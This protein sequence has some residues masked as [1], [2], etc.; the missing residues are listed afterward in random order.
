MAFRV[1]RFP[2]QRCIIK[3]GLRP[4]CVFLVFASLC[5]TL[6]PPAA[7]L[8]TTNI[9]SG[10]SHLA[11]E[12]HCF[13]RYV[14]ARPGRASRSN[15]TCLS[16]SFFYLACVSCASCVLCI[17]YVVCSLSLLYRGSRVPWVVCTV[18]IVVVC[19]L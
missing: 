19:I 13:G 3:I 6:V 5:T 10:I 2:C 17:V 12:L 14:N 9:W 1:Y 16:S 7:L 18:C 8:A 4:T 11:F 15:P